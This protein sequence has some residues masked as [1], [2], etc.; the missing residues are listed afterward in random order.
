M[1]QSTV[2]RAVLQQLTG[3][4]VSSM[5]SHYFL[6]PSH[7]AP[8]TWHC[9]H[10]CVP[11]TLTAFSIRHI[12][13]LSR[14]IG[15]IYAFPKLS[16]LLQSVTSTFRHTAAHTLFTKR[17]SISNIIPAHPTHLTRENLDVVI[18]GDT[19]PFGLHRFTV[20]W[21]PTPSS[22]VFFFKFSNVCLA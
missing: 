12:K 22:A 6:N 16:L 21:Q 10:L 5:H 13:L 3:R 17:F 19:L 8:V 4:Y 1:I 15:F 11:K 20:T 2:H 7:Q 14:G 9:C 18:H